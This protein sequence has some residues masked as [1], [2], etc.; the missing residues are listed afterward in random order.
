MKLLICAPTIKSESS[1]RDAVLGGADL[2]YLTNPLDQKG[3]VAKVGFTG[4]VIEDDSLCPTNGEL[5]RLVLTAKRWARH[6]HHEPGLKNLAFYGGVQ[7]SSLV[8]QSF[9]IELL[10]L[11]KP[12]HL[13]MKLLE[14]Y[15]IKA[16]KVLGDGVWKEA[17][18][19]LARAQDIP[20]EAVP[21]HGVI[22]VTPQKSDDI[23]LARKVLMEI[24]RFVKKPRRGLILYSS[25]PRYARPLLE[26]SGGC[27]LRDTFSVE[28]FLRSMVG[29]FVHLVPE[30]FNE[31]GSIAQRAEEVDRFIKAADEWFSERPF[32]VWKDKN[33]WPLIRECVLPRIQ[34]QMT[35]CMEL[36]DRFRE[37]FRRITPRAVVVDEEVCFFNKS[38]VQTANAFKIP[39]FTLVH[40]EPYDDIG[41]MPTSV[42]Y[43]LAW[44]PS[45]AKRLE[46]WGA[47][48]ARILQVGAPQFPV[49]NAARERWDVARRFGISE[50]VPLA[51]FGSFAFSTNERVTFARTSQGIKLQE[52]SLTAVLQ[53]VKR[54]PRLHLIIK[55]HP[56]ENHANFTERLVEAAGVDVRSRVHF[57]HKYDA[58]RLIAAADVVLT[59]ASTMYAETLLW[60]KP[61]LAFTSEKYPLIPSGPQWSVDVDDLPGCIKAIDDCFDRSQIANIHERIE[62]QIAEYFV[63]GNQN[64]VTRTLR[65]I[66]DASKSRREEI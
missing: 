17:A 52:K 11:L 42:S 46:E 18:F 29:G 65:A 51:L 36:V 21:T 7:Y 55:F 25:A 63:D 32:F 26:R 64:A 50:H 15:P 28:M 13:Y 2:V 12:I 24:N 20:I 54:H 41:N 38:L 19:F 48:P 47:D 22:N 6:W 34:T 4:P 35:L 56:Y 1:L 61:V 16:I 62:A 23:K 27:Y 10:A 58:T 57:V 33:L 59:I 8:T 39:T 30:Y 3:L 37:M 49:H 44:G 43:I 40:G 66:E 31:C 14:R 9:T 60:K 45:T 5:D 53:A